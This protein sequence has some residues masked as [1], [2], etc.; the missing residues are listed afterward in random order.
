MRPKTLH[1]KSHASIYLLSLALA[2]AA[3]ADPELRTERSVVLPKDGAEWPV[4]S[5]PEGD[6]TSMGNGLLDGGAFGFEPAWSRPLGSAYSGILVADGRLVTMFSDGE[7]DHL[8]ALDPSTGAEQW[9]YRISDTYRGR[10]GSDDGPL[11]TP[12]IADGAVYGL[13][14]R[15]ELFAVSLADGRER[16]RR[17][18]VADFGAVKPS[19]GFSTAPTAI[20]DV[21]VVETGAGDGRSILAL[22]RDSGELRWATGE[23]SVL[24]QSPM[25]FELGGETSLVAVTDRSLLGLDPGTGEV[26]WTHR[27]TEGDGR[28]FGSTQPV[29]V[30]LG[31]GDGGK[32]ILLIDGRES[33]LFRVAEN[34]GG[35][36]AEMYTVEEIWR[37]RAIRSQGNFANAVPYEGH[38]YGYAGSFL[39]CVDAATGETVWKSRPPGH[40][41]LVLVDGH[42]VI[43]ARSGEIVIAEAT[44]EGYSEVSRVQA[45]HRGYF[46]RPSFADGKIYVRNLTEISAI[47]ITD[48][49]LADPTGAQQV[50][51]DLRGDFGAFVEK[52]RVA[53]DKGRMVD[54]FL[55]E[56]G[57]LPILEGKWVHFVFRGE[58][59]DLAISGNFLPGSVEDPMH[60]VAGTDF[61]FRSYELP[62]K[63]LFTY[64]FSV[65]DETMTDPANPKTTGPENEKQSV[66]A[67]AGWQAPAHL[68]EPEG[69]R[70]RVETLRWKSEQLGNERDVQVYLPPGYGEG[71]DRYPLLLVNDSEQAIQLGKM[72]N[73]LDNLIGRTVAPVIVAFVPAGSWREFGGSRTGDY[74]RAQVEELIPVLDRTFRTDPRREARAVMG[75]ARLG[76]AAAAAMFLALHHPEAVSRAV[77][78]SFQSRRLEGDLMAAA[79]EETHD[80]ELLFHW[81]T[82][83]FFSPFNNFDARRDA[84]DLVAALER[85]GYRPKTF[86]SDDGVGWGMWQ[87]RMAEILE[88]LF[89][90]R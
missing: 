66:V 62:E 85:N 24:Y 77:A 74:T 56:H 10:D 67:T 44:P 23:D 83:D 29:P 64:G 39:T 49:G 12:T 70:G 19:F 45:L 16:W 60:R 65:F 46:T 82:N 14:A 36:N 81:S 78:Q 6:L 63:A 89:P 11:S 80:L 41:N 15:G 2:A 8:V 68:R 58:V 53:E 3:V 5:G 9:R 54:D 43:L 25:P 87:S 73:S 50:D 34:A 88:T 27:H 59:D 55:A 13:G 20:G 51:W 76:G 86:E 71:D 48:A 21:V 72:D 75:Q 32:G 28:R 40:G 79:S 33:A 30:R 69:R 57:T 52:L 18:L 22:D 26:L 17:D 1:P 90:L 38:L 42:L 31:Q 35:S 47:G 61:F 4:W 84:K 7:S 37:S